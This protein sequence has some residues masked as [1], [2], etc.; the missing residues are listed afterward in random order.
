MHGRKDMR[1]KLCGWVGC[2]YITTGKYYCAKHQAMADAR[3][4]KP[5]E[6]A[7]R[8]ADYSN[9]QWRQLSA[10]MIREKGCCEKCGASRCRLTVHHIIPVRYAPELFLDRSNM[11]VL[12]ESCHRLE[13]Q[14]EIFNRRK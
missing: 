10:Q 8:F 1:T 13:T 12:C 11:M 6:N 2:N 5:F 7:K 14:R 4:Q 9:P 3:K